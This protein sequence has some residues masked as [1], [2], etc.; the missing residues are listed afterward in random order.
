MLHFYSYRPFPPSPSCSYSYSVLFSEN[1]SEFVLL[2]INT[3]KSIKY[4][5]IRTEY[6]KLGQCTV[7]LNFTGEVGDTLCLD[8]G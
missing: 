1:P 4:L 7:S 6:F 5:K 8:M 3:I 2:E